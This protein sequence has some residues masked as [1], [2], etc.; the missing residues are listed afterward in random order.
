MGSSDEESGACIGMIGDGRMMS[1]NGVWFG[2]FCLANYLVI[3]GT[4][5]HHLAETRQHGCRRV[6][7]IRNQIQ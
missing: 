5:I 2:S 3:S 1:E 4:L 7:N 6:E